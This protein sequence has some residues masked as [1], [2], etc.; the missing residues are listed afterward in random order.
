MGLED[1][2]HQFLRFFSGLR[3]L[4]VVGASNFRPECSGR[5]FILTGVDD[6]PVE[7]N[8]EMFPDLPSMDIKS[9]VAL[10]E[11]LGLEVK[12]L[13][14]FTLTVEA[15]DLIRLTTES[16]VSRA[17]IVRLANLVTTEY[18][19]MLVPI[20]KGKPEVLVSETEDA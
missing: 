18:E 12:N 19:V 15:G 4:L 2:L 10:A 16:Y 1:C 11:A 13:R 5:F 17:Q 9:R 14:K 8:G 6:M 20:R 3:S 7:D